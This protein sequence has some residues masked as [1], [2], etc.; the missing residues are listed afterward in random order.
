MAAETPAAFGDNRNVDTLASIDVWGT[1]GVRSRG[2][3]SREGFQE[4]WATESE[5]C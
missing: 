2:T 1:W 3:L 4:R 5:P